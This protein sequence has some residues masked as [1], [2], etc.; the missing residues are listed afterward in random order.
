MN[1]RKFLGA[2]LLSPALVLASISPAHAADYSTHPRDN[3]LPNARVF[4]IAHT[5]ERIVIGGDFTSLRNPVTG[6]SVARGRI[7]ML[8]AATGDLVR[9]WAPTANGS[10]RALSVS[11]D[12]VFAGGDFTIVSGH[13]RNRI[14]ALD[15]AS[16]A[17]IGGW[18]PSANG[19]VRALAVIGATLYAGGQFG[20]VSGHSRSRLAAIDVGSG[21]LRAGWAPS[22]NA[23]VYTLAARPDGAALLVGGLFTT[24]GGS[25]RNYLGSVDAGTGTVTGWQPPPGCLV[26]SNQ[27][28]VTDLAVEGDSAYAAIA[29]PGGRLA[30]YQLDTGVRRW[31]RLADGD[32]ES[33]A[34]RD[35]RVYAGGHF[36]PDFSGFM[37][38]DFAAVDAATGAVDPDFAPTANGQIFALDAGPD[39]LR[40]GGAYSRLNDEARPY[41]NEFPLRPP[42]TDITLIASSAT[43]RYQDS[44]ADLGTSWSQPA[45]DDSSWPSGPAQLGFGDGDERRVLASGRITYY[46]RHAFAVADPAALHDV[47][48]RVLRDDGAVVYLN[49]QEV[50]RSNMPS[51]TITSGTLAPSTVNSDAENTWQ[52][53][54]VAPERLNAGQNTIAVEVHQAQPTSS[55]VSFDLALTAR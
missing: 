9:T 54:A 23:T 13:G 6:E 34:V 16:G 41:Y 37:R 10:V 2:L 43:W 39:A 29:G 7:A 21:A 50:M 15:Q 53:V 4:A 17:V 33:V 36:C 20:S 49:G 27:C 12:R 55:D 51:G 42:S 5:G 26:P 46:F 48:L 52:T 31:E 38:C 18:N 14:V 32:V 30:A 25:A 11:G 1:V 8:D 22:A 3:W 28:I 44:G 47:T 45:Y 19:S 35:G 24:L 40:A